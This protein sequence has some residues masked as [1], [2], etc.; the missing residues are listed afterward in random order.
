MRL[1]VVGRNARRLCRLAGV[2]AAV[3]PALSAVPARRWALLALTRGAAGPSADIPRAQT[4]ALPGGCD[5]ALARGAEQV[6]GYGFS[7][8]DTLTLSSAGR[9]LCLQ[10]SV[11]TLDGAVLEPQ[12]LALP[13][14]LAELPDEDAMLTCLLRLLSP[15]SA[16]QINAS[17][18]FPRKISHIARF[19]GKS[20]LAIPKRTTLC[21]KSKRSNDHVQQEQ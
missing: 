6:I 3:F 9:M 1:A 8:R 20:M 21:N 11:V 2:E 13:P 7:A 12:E 4:L 15:E 10:R 5:P 18:F 17:L 19:P 16:G 14:E